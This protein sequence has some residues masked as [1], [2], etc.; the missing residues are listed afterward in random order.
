MEQG[1]WLPRFLLRTPFCPARLDSADWCSETGSRT[2][3]R[4]AGW[5]TEEAAWSAAE[6]KAARRAFDQAYQRKCADVEAQVRKMIASV[7][8]PSDL[9]Q[10]HDYLSE[11]RKTVDRTFDY[12]YSVLLSVFGHLLREGWLTEADL[13]GL[14]EDKIEKIKRW[15]IL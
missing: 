3:M 7:S 15:A 8:S 9:W 11:Q 4:S 12:R 1:A 5:F 6:K 10:I 2:S 13:A 14:Q